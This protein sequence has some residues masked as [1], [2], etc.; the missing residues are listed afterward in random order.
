[1]ISSK[2]ERIGW[3]FYDWANSAFSATVVTV[4]IGPFLTSLAL[5]GSDSNG[6]IHI[7][8][9][10]IFNGSYFAY[11]LSLSVILQIFLLP[12]LGVISD[13]YNL[14]KHLLLIFA[15][16]G[17]FSTMAMF[18][19]M[20]NRYLLGGIL[21]LISNLSFGI[22]VVM[23]N[24]YLNDIAESEKRDSVSS[25]GWAFGYIGGAILLTLNLIL[26]NL[27]N[28]FGISTE[29]AVRINLASAGIWWG[30]FT[31]FPAF[32]LKKRKP[33]IILSRKC[34]VQQLISTAK[35][36]KYYPQTMLFLIAYLFY[37]DG[38]QAVIS[39][40]AQFGEQELKL[41]ISTITSTVLMVQFV[42]FFGS[43][44]FNYVSKKI[45][46]KSTIFYA[47]ILWIICLMAVYFLT[48]N[49]FQFVL[50]ASVIG[51]IMGGTQAISRSLFSRIIPVG[52]EAEYFSL[53]EVS[54]RGTSWMGPLLFG[55]SLQF[56]QSYRIAIFNLVIF[57]IIGLI[58]LLKFN[59]AKAESQ[60]RISY[61]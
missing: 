1:M 48:T 27:R 32:L 37:N 47:L 25:I 57:F 10:K 11:I 2:Q 29:M 4:F 60:A 51:L 53:Y 28:Q 8:G 24:A 14:K 56:T 54:E 5:K 21:F 13:K 58:L 42:A 3:Y 31:I 35:E 12:L 7:F 20:D 39:L 18:F 59:F 34:P 41:S 36:S 26:F 49:E 23:Y 40:S 33:K 15:Y 30:I 52:K 50:I 61:E 16:I 17:A 6:F 9:L 55:L 19:L 44:L 22:S 45:G 46:A 43:L 38:I